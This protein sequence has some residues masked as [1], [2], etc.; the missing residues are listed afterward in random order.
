MFTQPIQPNGWLVHFQQY[1]LLL[2]LGSTPGLLNAATPAPGPMTCPSV[3]T[4]LTVLG[5]TYCNAVTGTNFP[6]AQITIKN[7]QAGLQYQVWSKRGGDH[8]YSSRCP[9]PCR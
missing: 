3:N 7:S 2:L 5:S 8:E 6:Q 1:C 9:A 4:E